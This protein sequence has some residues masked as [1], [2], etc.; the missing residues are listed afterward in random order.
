MSGSLTHLLDIDDSAVKRVARQGWHSRNPLVSGR[1]G[2]DW[3]LHAKAIEASTEDDRWIPR[4]CLKSLDD[5]CTKFC[6]ATF[7]PD[8]KARVNMIANVLRLYDRLRDHGVPMNVIFKGGVMLRLVL[9]EFWG[10]QP[11][12]A[13]ECAISHLQE[14]RAIT[15]GDFD[16]E[17]MPT[18][19]AATSKGSLMRILHTQY[20]LLLWLKERMEDE[21]R[22]GASGLMNLEWDV[23]EASD[24]LK[25][26]L[27]EEIDG[28]EDGSDPLK[29][30]RVE[31]VV[32]GERVED[33]PSGYFTRNGKVAPSSRR[34][35]MIYDC[36]PSGGGR[37]R[38]TC[39]SD[40]G[41]ALSAMGIT[42]PRKRP[43]HSP[44]Y[45]TCSS[46]INEDA[47]E[48]SGP[49]HLHPLFHLAR[50]KHA[51]VLY[52]ETADGQKRC[53][54]LSGEMV[55][56]SLGDVGDELKERKHRLM[57]SRVAYTAYELLGVP[58]EV[59]TFRSYSPINFYY[60]HQ[61]ML[62]F[63]GTPP[64][65]VAKYEKRV[66]RYICFLVVCLFDPRLNGEGA[67]V[68]DRIG[69]LDTLCEYTRIAH[70]VRNAPLRTGIHLV[71][72]F[73][74]LVHQEL[75]SSPGR[76][77]NEYLRAVHRHLVAFTGCIRLARARRL[78]PS[79]YDGLDITLLHYMNRHIFK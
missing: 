13:R 59:V 61:N 77:A 46:F 56:L 45:A 21:L 35:L 75:A 25:R 1:L 70:H 48:R 44:L 30:A 69:A 5:V 34:D 42:P 29:G 67:S 62:H 22:E 26:R 66:V 12:D 24:D 57:S 41:E 68:H 37:E 3:T 11:L 58:R 4:E 55:D 73:A 71:D 52:Y 39:V 27:Q 54:R 32:I 63:G 38:Q 2:A 17:V 16:F 28:I 36:S 51:F 7:F 31:R 65:E 33:P 60:D 6:S 50:I 23:G 47:P 20:A 40:A 19:R 53:D 10:R 14:Q 49:R 72:D 18:S 74:L 76:A 78:V 8:A 79:P 43:R 64:W 9:L 15:L